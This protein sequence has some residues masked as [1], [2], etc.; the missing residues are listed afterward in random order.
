MPVKMI[1]QSL[2][3]AYLDRV[4]RFVNGVNEFKNHLDEMMRTWS[5]TAEQPESVTAMTEEPAMAATMNASEA[6]MP[7]TADDIDLDAIIKD[8]DLEGD[9]GL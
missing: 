5:L 9:L 7:I 3:N 4:Q 1:D 6:A 8:I 2:V